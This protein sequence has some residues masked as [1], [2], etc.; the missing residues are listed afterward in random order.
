M[1]YKTNKKL[2]HFYTN[3]SVADDSFAARRAKTAKL[4]KVIRT[5]FYLHCVV[6]VICIA[7]SIILCAGF[8]IVKVCVCTLTSVV[9]AF[10]AVGDLEHVK[11]ISCVIDFTFAAGSFVSAALGQHKPLYITCGILMT[12]LGISMIV[13]NIAA[14]LKRSLDSSSPFIM[15]R[16]SRSQPS[17]GY[18]D[19]PEIDDIPDMPEDYIIELPAPPP[20]PPPQTGKM[21]E[22]ANQ[23]C[24]IICGESNKNNP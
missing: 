8:D 19:L 22:L 15:R 16:E 4:R 2:L 9:F 5:C 24:E 12:I 20:P 18:D 21:R 11:T 3:S 1:M 10:F 7:L 23:V 14:H 13:S 17:S 6:A